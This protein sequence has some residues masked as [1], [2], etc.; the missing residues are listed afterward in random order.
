MCP[1]SIRNATWHCPRK[2]LTVLAF[3]SIISERKT[4]QLISLKIQ[5]THKIDKLIMPIISA[6]ALSTANI[7]LEFEERN[8]LEDGNWDADQAIYLA[9][10]HV[11]RQELNA[12]A[13]QM[14]VNFGS[15]CKSFAEYKSIVPLDTEN[16]AS[17]VQAMV[18][19]IYGDYLPAI[20]SDCE[21]I[22]NE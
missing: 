13:E 21:A 16:F 4:A 10:L 11:A 6:E 12:Y 19:E 2:G 17:A 20:E 5:M 22:C 14:S 9:Q 18:K 3:A 15:R 7:A 8:L 1:S